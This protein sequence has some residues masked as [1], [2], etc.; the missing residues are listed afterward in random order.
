MMNL[1]PLIRQLQQSQLNQEDIQSL[2]QDLFVL[3]EIQQ[4]AL[5]ALLTQQI[6]NPAL[7]YGALQWL[8]RFA[9]KIAYPRA[10]LDIVGTGGDGLKTFNISTAASLVVASTGVKVAKHGGR[11][12]TSICGSTDVIEQLGIGLFEQKTDI[13]Q[14]L[15]TQNY[16]FITAPFFNRALK[17]IA[18]LRKQLGFA[19]LF[20]FLGPLANPMQPTHR[21]IGVNHPSLIMPFCHVLK[22]MSVAHALVIHSEDGLD[23]ISIHSLT[24]VGEVKQGQ[25]KNYQIQPQDYG[26]KSATLSEITGGDPKQNAQIIRDLFANHLAGA[27]KD[28]VV[29]NAAAGLYVS[30]KA[31]SIQEGIELARH[32]IESKMAFHLLQRLQGA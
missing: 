26:F 9:D 12:V 32:A 24:T 13:I 31:N 16:V 19:T 1:N 25:I 18:P 28:I 14:A 6:T 17:A 23:E 22:E 2:L 27:K 7:L 5:L 3:S 20:N 4:S 8:M 21:V 11:K 29:L 30:G 15:E 10:V